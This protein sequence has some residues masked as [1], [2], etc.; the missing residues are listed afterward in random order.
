MSADEIGGIMYD[1]VVGGKKV[2]VEMK[3]GT[4]YEGDANWYSS[5]GD[6]DTGCASFTVET[7]D[8]DVYVDASDVEKIEIV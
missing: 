1:S 6:N 2:R 5:P 3:D 4:V 7:D 8:D